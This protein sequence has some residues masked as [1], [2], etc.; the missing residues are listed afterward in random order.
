MADFNY[1]K[2]QAKKKLEDA[3]ADLEKS[4]K[5]KERIVELL[6]KDY[7]VFDK[8]TIGNLIK[9]EE[10]EYGYA[11]Y[12]IVGEPVTYTDGVV[13]P[14]R[15]HVYVNYGVCFNGVDD[16]CNMNV[17]GVVDTIKI[18]MDKLDNINI[19][20]VREFLK[21]QKEV[22]RKDFNGMINCYKSRIR[23]LKN[24][25]KKN[26]EKIKEYEEIIKKRKKLVF[27]DVYD[28]AVENYLNSEGYKD[29]TKKVNKDR[30]CWDARYSYT[31]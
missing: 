7:D 19:I 24:E 1:L 3:K 10:S 14:I 21:E 29:A 31:L 22:H 27:D 28:K 30:V 15:H 11:Y 13:I 6:Q 16:Y 26:E 5:E 20:T 9:V 18:P 12:L 4:I 8:F 23:S 25:I 2:K 17:S